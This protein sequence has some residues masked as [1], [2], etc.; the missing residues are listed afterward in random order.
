MTVRTRRGLDPNLVAWYFDLLGPVDYVLDL[1][2]G[3]GDIGRYRPMRVRR[4]IGADAA[5][6]AVRLASSHE[7]VCLW[8]GDSGTLP[9]RDKAFDAIIA[10]D[11]LEHL[12]KPW[13]IVAE[14]HR[15]LR[16][17]GR[18]IASV[19]MARASAVWDDYTHVRGFTK[20]ALRTLFEDYGFV[21][22]KPLPMGGVPFAGRAGLVRRL[23]T[24]LS[25]PPL[26]WMFGSSYMILATK[27]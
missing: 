2:C 13:L 25:I 17:G 4:V 22:N 10:K 9:F 19:P 26:G 5:E 1:G 23:P 21:A 6:S 24:I 20:A 8:N 7:A 15:V 14:M 3:Q 11:V 12:S 18:V 27:P 16:N